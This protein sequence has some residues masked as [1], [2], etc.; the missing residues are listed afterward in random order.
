MRPADTP[1]LTFH[2]PCP[3]DVAFMVALNADP[4]VVRYTGDVAFASPDEALAVV[5]IL[6]E[7]R[8]RTRLTRWIV[9]HAGEPIG[10]CGL[11]WHDDL[12]V[13]D[14]GYRFVRAAWGRGFATE[15]SRAVLDFAFGPLGLPRV[16]ADIDPDNARSVAVVDRLGFTPLGDAWD[17]DLR[18]L[19]FERRAP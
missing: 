7:R 17:G 5:R 10:W 15:A 19:R 3:D 4:E 1:R 8:L 18:V 14:L 12:G 2:D 9:R 6:E 16:I 11:K 13:A